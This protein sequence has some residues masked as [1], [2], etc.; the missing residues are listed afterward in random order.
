[1][2]WGHRKGPSTK[3]MR[4]DR[5]NI[6]NK[7]T[8]KAL[9]KYGVTNKRVEAYNYAIKNKLSMD[10]G[11]GGHPLAGA[12]YNKMTREAD[13]LEMKAVSESGK[14]TSEIMLKKYGQEN[15]NRLNRSDK[16]NTAIGMA[17]VVAIPAA[18]LTATIASDLK[19]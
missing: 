14:R 19:R 15:I 13:K 2:K 10:D 3:D 5:R 16:I 17:A 4:S 11:G 12:K 9:N 8:N 18:I 7:E 6:N 1:M